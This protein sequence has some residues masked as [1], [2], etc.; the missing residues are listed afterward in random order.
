M[1]MQGIHFCSLY[2]KLFKVVTIT[3]DLGMR[4]RGISRGRQP[5]VTTQLWLQAPWL[6]LSPFVARTGASGPSQGGRSA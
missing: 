3:K 6:L 1:R 2:F 4:G 5:S